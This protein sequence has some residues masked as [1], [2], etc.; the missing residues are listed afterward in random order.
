MPKGTPSLC[1]GYLN[2]LGEHHTEIM[3]ALEK[4]TEARNEAIVTLA[5]IMRVADGEIPGLESLVVNLA[6]MSDAIHV[7]AVSLSQARVSASELWSAPAVKRSRR[8]AWD[9]AKE[10]R[11]RERRD[12]RRWVPSEV[13]A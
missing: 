8:Q 4:M 5:P 2:D 3:L 6:K 9:G 12:A 7:A 1:D 10:R 11:T 13:A